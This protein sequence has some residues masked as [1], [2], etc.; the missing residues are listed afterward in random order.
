M[1]KRIKPKEE[2][3]K[4]I[5]FIESGYPGLH[6]DLHRDQFK[7]GDADFLEHLYRELNEEN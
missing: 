1:K 5:N 3:K 7:K 4:I 6:F 2:I